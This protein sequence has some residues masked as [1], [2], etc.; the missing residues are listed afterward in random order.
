MKI[1]PYQKDD[2]G[3][4]WDYSFTLNGITYSASVE[5]ESGALFVHPD[6][7]QLNSVCE[8]CA[9]D[10]SDTERTN[11]ETVCFPCQKGNK[12]CCNK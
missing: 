4:F 11:G 6:D 3:K 9:D 8:C 1:Y 10:L 5:I 12:E 2:S 7:E